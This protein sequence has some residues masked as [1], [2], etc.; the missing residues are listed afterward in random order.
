MNKVKKAATAFFNGD[1]YCLITQSIGMIAF[2]DQSVAPQFLPPTV[3]D[4][5]LGQTLRFCLDKS[6]QVDMS[7]FQSIVSAGKLGEADE[8]LEKMTK[9][10]YGYKTKRAMY[11]NMLC[12][13]IMEVDGKIKI[14][15][16]H[17]KSLDT[18]S[19]ISKEGTEILYLSVSALDTEF[20]ESLREGFKRC[21]SAV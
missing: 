19:G 12:C 2:G 11:K 17:H 5:T 8:I 6:R 7:E 16:T 21:T 20:G 4:V 10:N 9:Q 15:P 14:I 13:W 3:D 18:Y 1:F